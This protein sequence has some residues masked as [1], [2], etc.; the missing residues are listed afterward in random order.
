LLHTTKMEKDK[1]IS[2]ICEIELYLTTKI[3][4]NRN[5]SYKPRE[6]DKDQPLRNELYMLRK[7]VGFRK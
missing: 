3:I 2:R 1:I 5:T 4:D 7:K 6:D